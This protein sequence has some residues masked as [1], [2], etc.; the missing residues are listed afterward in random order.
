MRLLFSHYQ[1]AMLRGISRGTRVGI[2]ELDNRTL[3]GLIRKGYVTGDVEGHCTITAE[4]S[5][6]LETMLRGAMPLRRQFGPVS[7]TVDK[8]LRARWM[9]RR[10]IGA[11]KEATL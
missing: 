7:P 5:D 6:V 9:S 2:G 4:G 8:L 1:L 11:S 3:A 10:A